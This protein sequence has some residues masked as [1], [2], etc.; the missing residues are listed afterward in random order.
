MSETLTIVLKADGSGLTGTVR[1]SAA[2]VRK[3]GVEVD[4]AGKQTTATGQR[5]RRAARDVDAL[6]RSNKDAT[7]SVS[8]LARGVNMLTGV[9]AT[10]GI[11][12]MVRETISAGLAMD[13]LER[14]T[15]AALG[16][17]HLAGKELAFVRTEAQRLGIYFPT[18]AQGYAGLAAATRGTILAGEQTREIF[19]GVAES[20][21]AMN[22]TTDQMAGVMTALQ[23]IAGKGTL[24]ME[25]LRQQLG[26]RLPG[27]MQIAAKSMNL[28]VAE[29][30]KLVSEGKVVSEEFLP[31]FA[32]E[33]R[34][35][36]ATGV[37]LAK[38]SPAAEFERLK[39]A[40]FFAAVEFT[41]GGLLAGLGKG[42][43]D[44]ASTVQSLVASGAIEKVGAAMGAA[45]KITVAWFLLF[46]GLPAVVAGINRVRDAYIG[47]TAATA[48]TT[49]AT[50]VWARVT[51]ASLLSVQAA[52]GILFAAFAGWH[53]GTYLREQFLEV[54]LAGIALVNGLLKGWENLK[55]GALVAWAL[56]KA[57]FSAAVAG[58]RNI[59]A[60]FVSSQARL[61]GLL[62]S[63][64]GGP[65]VEVGL[66]VLEAGLRTTSTAAADL[67]AELSGISIA[68]AA[69]K[70]QIDQITG[71]M[72]DYAI[73]QHQAADA[74]S[75]AAAA[76]GAL[77]GALGA[78]T[79]TSEAASA[80][81]A[82]RARMARE[83]A[84]AARDLTAAQADAQAQLED[85]RAELAGPAAQALLKYSRIER[86]LDLDVA[87]GILTWEGYADAMGLVA[88]MRARDA[89]LI[90]EWVKAQQDAAE[91]FGRMWDNVI[92]SVSD[93]F[94]DWMTGGISSFKDFGNT[95]VDIA[96]RFLSDIISTFA[97]TQLKKTIAGWATQIAGGRSGNGGWVDTLLDVMGADRSGSGSSGSGM[98]FLGTMKSAYTGFTNG[99]SAAGTA[100]QG[101][102][103]SM[104]KGFSGAVSAFTGSLST[105]STATA[106]Y[107]TMVNGLAVNVPAAT[108]ASGATGLAG[109][110]AGMATAIPIVGAIIAGMMMNNAAYK[111][112][113]RLDEQ[114][115]DMNDYFAGK[116]MVGLMGATW[117]VNTTDKM[118]QKLGLSG[119]DASNIS[120]SA[121]HAK[122]FGHGPAR[123][124]D[125]GFSGSVG[126]GGFD[127]E[128]FANIKRKGG[129]FRS[130]K[131]WQETGAIAPVIDEAFDL[132]AL[133]MGKGAE[134]LAKQLGGNLTAAL[135]GIRI[136]IP[137]IVLD[138]DPD[139]AREQVEQQ[140][141]EVTEGLAAKVVAA[142]G[143]NR[144]L[145]DGFA[146]SEVMASLSASIALVTGGADKLG[147]ALST[148]ERENVARAV[149]W[150]GSLARENGTS[151]GEE[152]QRVVGTIGEYTSLIA[153]VDTQLQTAGLNQYQRAQLDVEMGY[154]TQVKQANELAKSLGLTGAR[155][156]DL[157][158]IEQL[159]AL[160][161]AALQTQMEA[162]KDTF[163]QDLGLGDLSTLRDDQKLAESMQLL[164]DAV[165]SGDIQ[166]AQQL[167]KDALGFG[168][169]LYA[170]GAD[171]GGLY[172]EVTGLIDGMG[173]EDMAGFTEAQLDNIADLLT[174]LPENIASALFNSLYEQATPTPWTPPTQL[175]APGGNGTDTGG[176]NGG[177]PWWKFGDQLER[178]NAR[179]AAI[180]GNT[181]GS[182]Q[183]AK[184][185]SLDRLNK[186]ALA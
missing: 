174:D 66:K 112:G 119:Q 141:A 166:R 16:S 47:L 74:V 125:S 109:A 185:D 101:F 146:A 38:S 45:F 102:W 17:Q 3:F 168:R 170:S 144:L 97:S 183:A 131:N 85:W 13:R 59:L 133:R 26:D 35:A 54:E 180:E 145:D 132:V 30:V 184:G 143:F 36:A 93:A 140:L 181:G 104:V 99:F 4:R 32:A 126:L 27:A 153:G 68:G 83:T 72:A 11:S 165:G 25:E 121:L 164:R 21:R 118:L 177:A 55:A 29:F 186:K 148:L 48:A 34:K 130:D 100:G 172:N 103:G 169:D 39:T 58:M 9:L 95:L 124:K 156:E 107:T 67:E 2:E 161:M 80:A 60:D 10:L 137:Q 91:H 75:D 117:T 76:E 106:G 90:P 69:N 149:E 73:A 175:P 78:T 178:M 57:G 94:G 98:G 52:A 46:R 31:K 84:Q 44:L 24:S 53:I 6:G 62:P 157:A 37:E 15:A 43:G 152:L 115:G 138:E 120:G 151:L 179:L 51:V 105:A 5:S 96:K 86:E 116:G 22:L 123:V 23:Q 71:E 92:G 50:G 167:A 122:A 88:E 135:A 173:A 12:V 142:M 139:K 159:R 64:M 110:S 128:S 127:G 40:L 18:L 81:S 63:F 134:S 20:G 111:Q 82:E 77:A 129:W 155:S 108:G 61:A 42:A 114:D 70:E 150:I 79:A 49:T 14:S 176:P 56:I 19:L 147:R 171:Y 158:K 89:D 7:Q 28:P 113:W 136:D 163:L 1:A 162:Q 8:G 33:M 160:N 41:R 182:L 154:R 65:A 87:A